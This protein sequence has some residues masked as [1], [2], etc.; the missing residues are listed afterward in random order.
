[1]EIPVLGMIVLPL[2]ALCLLLPARWMLCLVFFLA[3]FKASSVINFSLGGAPSGLQAGYFAALV[4]LLKVMLDAIVVGRLRYS[5]DVFSMYSM[6]G[7]FVGYAALSALLLPGLFAGTVDVYPITAGLREDDLRP[8]AYGPGNFTQTVYLAVNV[9]LAAALANTIALGRDFL[10]ASRA[11]IATTVFIIVMGLYQLAAHYLGFWYPY[12]VINNNPGY[13]QNFAQQ[14]L[15]VKRFSSVFT[16][17]SAAAHWLS[18]FIPFAL[19]AYLRGVHGPWLMWVALAAIGCLLVA[20]S[21]TGYA[22]ALVLLVYGGYRLVLRLAR[23]TAII[24]RRAARLTVVSLLAA[25]GLGFVV[26]ASGIL[27]LVSAVMDQ[28]VVTKLASESA[29]RRLGGDA[30]AID[31]FL[32]TFG[33]GA[34]WGSNRASSQLL[35]VASTVGIAGLVILFAFVLSLLRRHRARPAALVGGARHEA[36]LAAH[37]WAVLGMFLAALFAAGDPNALGFWIGLAMYTALLTEHSARARAVNG[38]QEA[39]S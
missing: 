23:S 17:P 35:R 20:T 26:W 9:L 30:H 25:A 36:L 34:G 28:V 13:R 4:F 33:L 19:V 22:V 11:Y 15:D 18:G 3:P 39:P 29:A 7:L 31:V 37:G 27:E 32:A 16:E 2:A 6:L 12:D 1:M 8:L 24:P 38:L 5:R 10:F 21:T 14:V